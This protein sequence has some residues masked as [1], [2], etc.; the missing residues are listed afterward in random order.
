[1]ADALPFLEDELIYPLMVE[2][3]GC[4]CA[5]ND[6]SGMGP[7]CFCGLTFGDEPNVDCGECDDGCGSGWVR[8]INAFPSTDFFPAQDGEATCAT[9]LAASIEVGIIRCT[10]VVLED[11]S[12][13]GVSSQLGSARQQ[14]ADMALIRRAIRCCFDNKY[15]DL[16]YVLGTYTPASSDGGC[17]G[18]YWEITVR[19][20]F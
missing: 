20:V 18:G 7:M 3:S 13:P 16:D 1:M 19:Q 11:G 17:V 15:K 4:L 10:E 12:A 6:A 5:E 9:L 8:L 2:L 14:L